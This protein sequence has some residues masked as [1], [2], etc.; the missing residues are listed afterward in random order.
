MCRDTI[1]GK[2]RDLSCIIVRSNRRN[3]ITQEPDDSIQGNSAQITSKRS[4]SRQCQ[5]YGCKP[6][7]GLKTSKF[8][9]NFCARLL[10]KILSFFGHHPQWELCPNF[11]QR[12][13]N[14]E[15]TRALI[16]KGKGTVTTH[17][18]ART[19]KSCALSTIT[20]LRTIQART[21]PGSYET[22]FG[23]YWTYLKLVFS[24]IFGSK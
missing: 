3:L 23:R 8:K 5:C 6:K 4:A 24:L 14:S 12:P 2:I 21:L 13:E 11:S 22:Q 15:F 7:I 20:A 19:R 1:T 18:A 17:I 16:E 9:I 10:K